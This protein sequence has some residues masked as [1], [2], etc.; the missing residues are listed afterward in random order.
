M[1]LEP[2]KQ[3]ICDECGEVI[4]KPE[5]GWIEWITDSKNDMKVSGFRIVHHSTKSPIRKKHGEPRGP[6]CYGYDGDVG[7]SDLPLKDMVGQLGMARMLSML[8]VGVILDPEAEGKMRVGDM[9]SWTET[10][11]RL[12][13]P[14][15]EEARLCFDAAERDGYYSDANEISPFTAN[16]L[17]TV[18]EEYGDL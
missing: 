3:W 14:Y 8:D 2:L 17:K 6:S 16:S 1:K 11:R 9:R 18:I 15:Y 10:F 13:M 5:D 4:E 7:R 12:F